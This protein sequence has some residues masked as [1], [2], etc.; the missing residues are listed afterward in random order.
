MSSGIPT[1]VSGSNRRRSQRLLINMPVII[2]VKGG[3]SEPTR[4]ET[5]TVVVNAHGGLITLKAKV[6]NGQQLL[7]RNPKTDEERPCKVVYLG[8]VVEGKAQVGIEF[9]EPS[10][11]FWRI[12][13]PPED[14][15]PHCPESKIGSST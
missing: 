13:F 3:N 11:R 12:V 15:T 1:N 7:I 14:W 2:H 10:P 9:L 5:Q 6:A 4:E 8:P